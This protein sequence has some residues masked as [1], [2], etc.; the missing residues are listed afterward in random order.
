[1]PKI[2]IFCWTMFLTCSVPSCWL[3]LCS[4]RKNNSTAWCFQCSKIGCFALKSNWLL[5]IL[6]LA[7]I[8]PSS[9]RNGE[10]CRI[11]LPFG[12]S[13]SALRDFISSPN[14]SCCSSLKIVA[15]AFPLSSMLTMSVAGLCLLYV[16]RTY[17]TAFTSLLKLL[18]RSHWITAFFSSTC[19]MNTDE[20]IFSSSDAKIRFTYSGHSLSGRFNQAGPVSLLLSSSM[21]IAL[22]PMSAGLLIPLTCFHCEK[23]V[24]SSISATGLATN[25]CCLRWELC[26]HCNP[27][28]ESDQK[29]QLFIFISCS[30]TICSFN[31]TAMTAACN[32]NRGIERC[33]IGAT[34][35]FPMTNAK[36]AE[37][38]FVCERR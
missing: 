9:S 6:P 10:N 27:V 14:C 3:S 12:I 16:H 7:R 13:F 20:G 21:L 8:S 35:H 26:I 1:M 11:L 24:V 4:F 22:V 18:N 36:P 31:L 17:A 5:P 2:H 19:I 30:L 34:L 29:L 38:S 28:V 23:S 25:T 37:Y 32:S 33:L 15:F